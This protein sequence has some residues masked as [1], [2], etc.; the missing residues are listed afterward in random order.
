M[1]RTTIRSS[2][3]RM[4]GRPDFSQLETFLKVAETRSFAEAARQMG[5]S[6]PAVSQ[7]IARLEEIYGGDLFERR[8]GAPVSLTL[9]GRAILPKAKLLLF[10]VDTQLARA[11]DIAQSVA[12]SLVVGFC[13]GLSRGPLKLGIEDFRNTCPDVE[14]RFLEASANE[15]HRQLNERTIDIMFAP[16][17]PNL[18]GGPNA[19][20]HLWDERLH[21]ALRKDHPLA[22]NESLRWA[23]VSALPIVLQA[24]SG[25]MSTFRAVAARMGARPFE[26]V[27][28][29]VSP[30]TLMDMVALGLGATITCP[31]LTAPRTELELLPIVDENALVA[32][33]ALWPEEDRNPIRHRLLACVRK[34]TT[35]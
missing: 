3:H 12:G 25:D 20:E 16:H 2:R 19:Q 31:S 7:T 24:H 35:L 21:V 30:G 14:L 5:V 8:R 10:L 13:S 32:V 15:L 22:T 6:Q 9:I 18:L 4:L 28:H 23:D 27:L 29:D 17:L 1:A 26:C 33:E 11:V 34:Q